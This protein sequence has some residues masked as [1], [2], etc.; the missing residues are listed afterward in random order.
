VIEMA[1]KSA[2][3]RKAVMGKLNRVGTYVREIPAG[4]GNLYRYRS[5]RIGKTVNSKYLGKVSN[6]T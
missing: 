6:S 1:F 3:Q 2:K 5:I 4:S